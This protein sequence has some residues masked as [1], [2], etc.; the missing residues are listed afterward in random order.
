MPVQSS[1]V[2]VSA[3]QGAPQQEQVRTHWIRVYR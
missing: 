2:I 1:N 3:L